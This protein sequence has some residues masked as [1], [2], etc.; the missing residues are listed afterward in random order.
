M[1]KKIKILVVRYRFIGDTLLTVPF[2][3]NLRAFYPDAQIDMLVT[4]SSVGVI[5][6]CPYVDNF[7]YFDAS[8]SHTY[9]DTSKYN[10]TTIDCIRLLKRNRYDK[11]YLLKRSLTSALIVFWAG[12]KERIGFNTECRG[13]LLTKKVPYRD[14]THEVE[15]FL[16][17][18]RADDIPVQDN[19][20]EEWV[21]TDTTQF[22]KDLCKK[23]NIV[24]KKKVIIHATSGNTAKQWDLSYWSEV[25]KFVSNTKNAQIMFLGAKCDK[26]I[27]EKILKLIDIKLNIE[28]INLCGELT[29]KQSVA[30]IKEADLLIGCDSGNLHIAAAVKTPVIGIYGPMSS[31]KWGAVG[32]NNVLLQSDLPCVPCSLKH[33]CRNNFAC[34]KTITP[35]MVINAAKNLI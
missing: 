17:I 1:K 13:M 3:R 31:K 27:Y 8:N 16:N 12:V 10:N 15:S 14:D 22:A 33:K 20:L 7:I 24:D 28:P 29:L 19:Y 6:N 18:L 23:H 25:I 35:E 9:E 5:E 32:E 30:M 2:L 11:A 4:H 21:D 34:L 26:L